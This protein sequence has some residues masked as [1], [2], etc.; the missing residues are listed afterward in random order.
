MWLRAQT[1]NLE[2]KENAQ[3]RDADGV[4]ASFCVIYDTVRTFIST[5]ILLIGEGLQAPSSLRFR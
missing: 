3:T 5:R 1:A 4:Q 2:M